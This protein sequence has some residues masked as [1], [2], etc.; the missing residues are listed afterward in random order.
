MAHTPWYI[1]LS[2]VITI[3]G[4][5]FR[6]QLSKVGDVL[7][8]NTTALLLSFLISALLFSIGVCIFF[9]RSE[10]FSQIWVVNF[11]LG[12]GMVIFNTVLIALFVSIW[13][14][15]S[16]TIKTVQKID[17]EIRIHKAQEFT[18]K[19]EILNEKIKTLNTR[20]DNNIGLSNKILMI[21]Y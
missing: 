16:I 11:V 1:W 10:P 21:L 12:V 18:V 19:G 14:A 15:N 6:N 13:F 20:I 3:V 9:Y 5:L 8:G 7:F 17:A 2:P 4:L